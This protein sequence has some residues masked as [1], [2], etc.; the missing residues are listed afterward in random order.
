MVIN[1]FCALS[2]DAGEDA[3]NGL[4]DDVQVVEGEISLEVQILFLNC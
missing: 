3:I 4:N 1:L 2:H